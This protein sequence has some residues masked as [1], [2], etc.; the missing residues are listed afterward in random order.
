[1]FAGKSVIVTGGAG[2]FGSA[3]ARGFGAAGAQ[4]VV[5]DVDLDAARE[6]AESLPTAVA[7]RTDVTSPQAV[8]QLVADAVI[9][10]GGVD[11][12]V[13]NAG[14]PHRRAPLE[15]M[16]VE[17][18]DFQLTMNV[19][20]VFLVCK[21]ALPQLRKR[22]GS[23]IVNV[24]SIGARRPRRGMVIYNASKAAVLTLT[25]GLATELAPAIRVNA[26]NPVASE[27]GFVKNALGTDTFDDESRRALVAEIP[28]GRLAMPADVANSVLFLA[29][30]S[31]AFL[32]GV[33]LDVDG[34]RGI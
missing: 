11:V 8:E 19:R 24:A 27:T 6:V 13:N 22:P 31:A 23:S 32:T 30:E 26:V 20:S 7:I 25:R 1:L 28:M 12:L 21:L 9:T 14:L 3:I 18:V 17:D 5:S 16:S 4:V 34:G 10:F 33:C 15:A 2:G 29:S